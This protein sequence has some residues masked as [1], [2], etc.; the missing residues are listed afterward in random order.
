[1]YCL[2]DLTSGPVNLIFDCANPKEEIKLVL[3]KDSLIQSFT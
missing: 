3:D 2:I 1:M